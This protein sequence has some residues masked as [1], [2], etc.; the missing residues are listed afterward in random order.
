MNIMTQNEDTALIY[1]NK[2]HPK[3]SEYTYGTLIKMRNGFIIG[4]IIF[5]IQFLIGLLFDF[6]L[7]YKILPLSGSVITFLLAWYNIKIETPRI[8]KNGTLRIYKDRLIIYSG[9]GKTIYLKDLSRIRL[10]SMYKRV[11]T[12]EH[13]YLIYFILRNCKKISHSDEPF[14]SDLDKI[15]DI[16]K[17]IKKDVAIDVNNK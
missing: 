4:G 7:F 6:P 10:V 8:L 14:L 17:R 12:N 13:K 2:N 11:P 1:E 9:I 3:L 5:L 15:L 16:I